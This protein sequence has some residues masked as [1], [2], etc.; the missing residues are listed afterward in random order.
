MN[1]PGNNCEDLSATGFNAQKA[2]EET[3]EA[4]L[5]AGVFIEGEFTFASGITATL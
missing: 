4:L 3:W 5:G 2:A 1:T